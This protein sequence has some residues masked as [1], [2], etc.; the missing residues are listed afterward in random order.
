MEPLSTMIDF[1][2]RRAIV[3]DGHDPM[4]TYTTVQDLAAVVARAV[5]LDGE[6]PIIGGIRGNR[7]PASEI[8]KIGERVQGEHCSVY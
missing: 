6:W 1:Q 8:L 2:H 5:D 4:M 7:L 3:V